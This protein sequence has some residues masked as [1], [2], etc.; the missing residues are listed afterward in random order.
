MKLR[1]FLL[2]KSGVV[3]GRRKHNERG[4]FSMGHRGVNKILKR[5]YR[6]SHDL[7]HI[8]VHPC[9]AV[10]FSHVGVRCGKGGI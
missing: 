5:M 1:V 6:F 10:I 4:W 9:D 8:A 3:S 7:C 2:C